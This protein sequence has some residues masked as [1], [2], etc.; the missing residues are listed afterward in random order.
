M[1]HLQLRRIDL[2]QQRRQRFRHGPRLRTTDASRAS[3]PVFLGDE[4]RETSTERHRY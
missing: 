2:L 4:L 3:E 1:E